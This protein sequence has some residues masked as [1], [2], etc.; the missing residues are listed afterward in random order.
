MF[1]ASPYP[2]Y[3]GDYPTATEQV[4]LH[5][6]TTPIAL[7]LSTVRRVVVRLITGVVTGVVTIHRGRCCPPGCQTQLAHLWTERDVCVRA[8]TAGTRGQ[9]GVFCR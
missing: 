2:R 7:M 8:V 3:V 1:V 6:T 5:P 4:L 9:W